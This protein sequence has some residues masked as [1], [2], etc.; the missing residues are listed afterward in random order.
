MAKNDLAYLLLSGNKKL[1]RFIKTKIYLDY[2]QNE[3]SYS[4]G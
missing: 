2:V 4:D 1:T 3:L